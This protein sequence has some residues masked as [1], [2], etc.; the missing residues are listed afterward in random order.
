MLF[1]HGGPGGRCTIANTVFFDPSVYRVVLYDQRGAGQSTPANELQDNTTDHLIIDNEKIRQHV[2]VDTWHM[3]F[4]GSWGSTLALLYA[5]AFPERVKSLVLRGI[6]LAR[7]SEIE[8]G[9]SLRGAGVDLLFPEAAEEFLSDYTEEEQKDWQQVALERLTKGDEQT[10]IKTARSLNIWDIT[11]G[12]T[13]FNPATSFKPLEDKSWSLTHATLEFTYLMNGCYIRENRIL[14]EIDNIK[15]IPCVIIHGR[16]D[17]VCPVSAAWDLHKAM[18]SSRIVINP[19]S[20]H[21]AT[22]PGNF[23]ELIKACDEFAKL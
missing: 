13:L 14:E 16:Y 22:D 18:P 15:H 6:F 17:T 5:Q 4:G 19:D 1:L 2:K 11:R 23:K 21:S 9:H 12:S 20:G 3:V 7:K 10:R 8:F